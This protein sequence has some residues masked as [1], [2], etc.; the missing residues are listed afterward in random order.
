MPEPL[1]TPQQVREYLA[2]ALKTDRKYRVLEFQHGW[3]CRGVLTQEEIANGQGMGQG[4]Y[5]VNK[6]TGVVTAHSSLH[7]TTIGENYD[8]AIQAG[9]PVQGYQ[10][11]PPTWRVHI[12]RIRESRA[13]IDYRVRAE[14]LTQP[15]QP[16]VEHHLI[17]NKHTHRFY[18]ET[19]ATHVTC[20]QAAGWAQARSQTGAWPETGTFE[21]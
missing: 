16:P 9:R 6:Q 17:I 20:R 8:A 3:V 2:R 1:E 5:V 13:E 21:F 14:S 18:T 7:P 10:V 19:P 15:P 11:H 12:E 4:S